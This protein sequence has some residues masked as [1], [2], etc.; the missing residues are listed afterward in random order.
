MARAKAAY[1]GERV[2]INVPR[3]EQ[4]GDPNY[5]ISVNGVN[6]VLPKGKTSEVPPYVAEEFYRAERAKEAFYDR[7]DELANRG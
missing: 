7:V 6:Y 1:S 3:G 2:S 5:F 4:N